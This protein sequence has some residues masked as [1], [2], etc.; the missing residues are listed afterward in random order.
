[1]SS[2]SDISGDISVSNIF[3]NTKGECKGM[4]KWYVIGKI[5]GILSSVKTI[6]LLGIGFVG[7]CL[8]MDDHNKR[9]KQKPEEPGDAHP[10]RYD[11]W[12]EGWMDGYKCGYFEGT[13]GYEPREKFENNEENENAEK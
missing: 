9:R 12:R 1:M 5:G 13:G 4:N 6:A 10:E 2:L 11:I 8:L 7:G 3:S